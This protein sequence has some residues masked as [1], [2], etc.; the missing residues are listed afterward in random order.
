MFQSWIVCTSVC[1]TYDSIAGT[2]NL[3]DDTEMNQSSQNTNIEATARPRALQTAS[4]QTIGQPVSHDTHF[5]M[6]IIKKILSLILKW[7][8]Y[9]SFSFQ[10]QRTFLQKETQK[11]KRKYEIII[12]LDETA[13]GPNFL[14]TPFVKLKEEKWFWF[15][16][17]NNWILDDKT[18]MMN[19]GQPTLGSSAVVCANIRKCIYLKY[20]QWFM[21]YEGI[22]DGNWFIESHKIL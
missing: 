11:D 19:L 18:N 3:S 2:Q 9:I 13:N 15:L 1:T 7:I 10:Q 16:F 14:F 22:F 4:Q 21:F 8:L 12:Y 6:K 17:V 5:K 20:I